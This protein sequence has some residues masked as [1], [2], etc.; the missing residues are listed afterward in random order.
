MDKNSD[1]EEIS[2][3]ERAERDLLSEK[4]QHQRLYGDEYASESDCED[5]DDE[6][7]K[8]CEEALYTITEGAFLE[9]K[10]DARTDV[11]KMR[12]RTG[13]GDSDAS[14][15]VQRKLESLPKVYGL[16]RSWPIRSAAFLG[17]AQISWSSSHPSICQ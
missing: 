11:P 5:I 4:K 10:K 7:M 6:G 1:A 2:T 12:G 13:D 15:C 8:A 17:Y 3:D 9:W 14:Q 16:L